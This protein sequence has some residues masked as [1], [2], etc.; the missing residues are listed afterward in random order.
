LILFETIR[1][2]N[3]LSTGNS[4]TEINFTKNKS[5]LIVGENGAGKSTILDALCFGL[6]GKPFRK[7]NKPL[8][9]NAINQ[10]GLEVEIEFKIGKKSYKVRR[11]I[12]PSIFE[13]YQDGNLLNQDADSK[14]YQETFEKNILKLNFK[15]FS[16][17]VI[18]GSASFVPFMQLSAANRRE[19]IEDLL[20]I[21]IFTTMN[22]I[23]K[24]KISTNKNNILSTD[25]EL[26]LTAEKIEM[27][28]K[29]LDVL[30]QN[31]ETLIKQKEEKIDEYKEHINAT[32]KELTG[33][34]ES[35]QSLQK[36]TSQQ[37]KVQ[38]KI[39][40]LTLLRRSLND[41]IDRLNEDIKFFNNHH[42]CPTCKQGIEHDHK[43]T[44]IDSNKKQIDEVQNGLI[45]LEDE[46]TKNSNKLTEIKNRLDQ[47][48]QLNIE[49]SSLNTKITTWNQFI[50]DLQKEIESI[51]K[52]N[53]EDD[54]NTEILNSLKHELKVLIARKEELSHDKNVLDVAQILLKDT[55]IK[56]KIIKQYI[57]IINKL[58]NKYLAAMDFFVNF[59]LNENFEEKIKSRHRDEF[60]YESFSEGEK[61]RID[62]SLLFT[63]RAVAKLR[64][65]ASTN[66]LIMDEVFDSSLDASGTDEFLKLLQGLANDTNVFIISHKGD[67]L[68]DKFDSVIRFEKVKNFSRI[69]I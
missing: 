33:L 59:E 10:K 19:V 11:G 22:T 54:V 14:E 27:H 35:V 60:S 4:F 9:I 56:T 17:I 21:Q 51:N 62:L 64:N 42:D 67:T 66:L 29:H 28:K 46:W 13:I 69:A 30:K 18:L 2:K 20:D 6:Y 37:E 52:Q 45:K 61:L 24:E 5:T 38:K 39:N 23:L 57:P 50:G 40:N 32:T 16:Q 49:C 43:S 15:S 55:G 63:W 48:A 68:F 7:I 36:E 53:K 31:N 26:K 1:W 3:F 34:V 25:Y 58:I 8:L 44:I 65:S 41:K 12:K 47:I